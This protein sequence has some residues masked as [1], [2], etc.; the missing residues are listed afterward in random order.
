ML[1]PVWI[2]FLSLSLA[3]ARLPRAHFVRM[4]CQQTMYM[5]K[6]RA[7]NQTLVAPHPTH[8]KHRSK[9]WVKSRTHIHTHSAA[10][11]SKPERA[12]R[13]LCS[14]TQSFSITPNNH[15]IHS[16]IMLTS[17]IYTTTPKHI[18]HHQ[19][20]SAVSVCATN[21]FQCSLLIFPV[22]HTDSVSQQFI[23]SNE[24]ICLSFQSVETFFL[25]CKNPCG[26]LIAQGIVFNVNCVQRDV[27]HQ[28]QYLI[29]LYRFH[30]ILIDL[31]N[32][33]Q[34]TPCFPF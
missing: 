5:W 21:Q 7:A 2:R 32:L 14:A 15:A 11:N 25:H 12:Y 31:N 26:W 6:K 20:I 16:F 30:R 1:S 23:V 18:K 9:W 17:V 3:L 29:D 8:S 13:V 22:A 27:S 10:I 34:I 19:P 28:F 24:S 33:R 4:P